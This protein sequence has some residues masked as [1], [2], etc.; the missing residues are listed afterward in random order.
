MA[1]KAEARH[2]PL[3]GQTTF[4]EESTPRVVVDPLIEVAVPIAD[5]PIG[6]YVTRHVEVQLDERQ[7]TTLKRLLAG[8]DRAG[9]R[10]ANQR[11]VQSHADALKWLLEELGAR[12]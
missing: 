11:R 2:A 10:L 5:F 8:L 9:R 4:L 3:P 7:A 12:G 6:A 1:R